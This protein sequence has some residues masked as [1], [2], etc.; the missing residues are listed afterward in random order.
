MEIMVERLDGKTWRQVDPALIFAQDDRVRFRFHTNFDG[1]LYV[2][3][4]STSGKYEQLFPR[5]E[6]GRDNLVRAGRDYLVPATEALF[7]VT[8]PPG[9]EMVYWIVT[10]VELVESGAHNRP[11]PPPLP[12]SNANPPKLVPRCDDAILKARGDCVDSSAGPK[13]V[14]RGATLPDN[15]AGIASQNARDI[16][17][18]RQKNSTVVSSPAPLNG[19]GHLRVP[20]GPQVTA[21]RHRSL[22]LFVLA[23]ALAAQQQ[24]AQRDLKIEKDLKA[25]PP[26]PPA[27]KTVT[28][29]RSYALVVGVAKY[30]KLPAKLQLSYSERDAESIYSI[31]I[32]PEGGNFKAENVHKLVGPKATLANL[33]HELETWLPSVAK[34]DDRVLIYFAGHGFVYKGAA[35]LAPYDFDL[36]NVTT[37]GYPMST[38]RRRDRRQDQ[39]EIEDPAHGL[40]PQ[41]RDHSGRHANINHT[42]TDLHKSLF[43]LT[44]SRDRERSFESPD[45]G[46]GHGIFTYY[47][48]QGLGG[49]A[50][51]NGD[52]IVTADELAEYVH[53]QVREATQG[54]QNPTS[55][56]GS[57]D[58]E[59]AALL[60]AEQRQ[61]R[62]TAPA[63]VRHARFRSQHG[64]RGG[65]RGR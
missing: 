50:D 51:E 57:F 42:L 24:P 1:Y 11:A 49:A 44:A 36:D 45:F 7:R 22:A 38:S 12:R 35:Y 43:S 31:L 58:A 55:D 52:G 13:A 40:L 32:S 39:G 33:R 62:R 28:I 19:S 23:G 34:D 9:H 60:C 2:M 25:E 4:Q 53:T 30:E 16:V 8:G 17:I 21:M 37:S 26:A 46:G 27:K 6:T 3:N 64:R 10:P 20:P 15:L 29:P 59:Y 65:V 61:A 54:Q 41:R 63:Q 5:E 14:P 56:Q 18:M 47:V 48:V